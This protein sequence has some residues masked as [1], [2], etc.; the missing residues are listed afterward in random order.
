M[1]PPKPLSEYPPAVAAELETRLVIVVG[2]GVHSGNTDV[3]NKGYVSLPLF[4][5]LIPTFLPVAQPW[6]IYR[7]YLAYDHNDPIYEQE[8][9]RKAVEAEILRQ[10]EEENRK[11][12][13]PEGWKQ[14]DVDAST[15]VVTVHF[16]HCNYAG[17]PAWAHSDAMMTGFKEGADYGFRTNDDTQLPSRPD[18][19]DL[20]VADLRARR[21][22]PNLGV[23]GPACSEG[24]NWILTHDFT[25][26]THALVFG[27]QYPR[28]LP[29]WS[30]DDWITYMYKFYN[31]MSRREDA[32]VIHMLHGQR[33]S[34][35]SQG[36]RLAA[37]NQALV[38]GANAMD[39]FTKTYYDVVLPKKIDQITCC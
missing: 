36:E 39:T 13:H 6:H 28:S 24:A 9:H 18:W 14:G 1:N 4:N 16:V 5:T 29:N 27:F 21:P 22:V 7:F 11:R 34:T 15:L 33:Y 31:M 12:W 38:D 32:K 23:V 19:A 26:R 37:L 2:G 17:K 25:H 35:S 30:S 20:F 10:V 8:V 3:A